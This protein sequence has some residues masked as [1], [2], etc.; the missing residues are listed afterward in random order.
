MKLTK[1]QINALKFV[2][3]NDDKMVLFFLEDGRT[4]GTLM[5]LCNRG[6]LSWHSNTNMTAALT[7]KEYEDI[8]DTNSYVAITPAGRS[9]L[10]AAEGREDDK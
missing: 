1:A 6:L 10:T 8:R 5:A 9:A 3:T 4:I 7:P 2:A